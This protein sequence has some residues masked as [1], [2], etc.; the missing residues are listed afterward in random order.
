M[1]SNSGDV[2]QVIESGVFILCRSKSHPVHLSLDLLD[3]CLV[4]KVNLVTLYI[5][6]DVLIQAKKNVSHQNALD[7]KLSLLIFI[8][9]KIWRFTIT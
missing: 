1:G 9:Y 4:L 2:M 6:A 3:I 7:L 8:P 5:K